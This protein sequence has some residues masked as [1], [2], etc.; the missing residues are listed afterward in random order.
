M[1]TEFSFV[2]DGPYDIALRSWGRADVAGFER[3]LTDL[4]SDARW[5]PG[6]RSLV[7]FSELDL[8][9]LT[10]DDVRRIA[11]VHERLGPAMGGALSAVVAGTATNFGLIRMFGTFLEGRSDMLAH[12]FLT[13]AEALDWLAD[14]PSTSIDSSTTP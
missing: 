12:P 10:T 2:T 9:V 11:D 14:Q 8:G 7:D 1:E 3:Y 13:R 5:R 4:R 6:L